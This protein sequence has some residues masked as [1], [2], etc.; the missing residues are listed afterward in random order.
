MDGVG[1]S[2]LNLSLKLLAFSHQMQCEFVK[3]K[4]KK[5]P[6]VHLRLRKTMTTLP[7]ED[8]E[9]FGIHSPAVLGRAYVSTSRMS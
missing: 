6:T 1:H 8:S 3:K 7:S 5:F 9:E 2:N 4:K